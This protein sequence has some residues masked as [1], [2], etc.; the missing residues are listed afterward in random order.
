[1]NWSNA[2][3]A[4]SVSLWLLD[5]YLL[6]TLLLGLA[7]LGLRWVRQP[8]HRLTVA[9]IVTIELAALAGVCALPG[10]PKI[11]LV[12]VIPTQAALPPA[13]SVT[14]IPGEPPALPHGVTLERHGASDTPRRDQAAADRK[15]ATTASSEAPAFSDLHWGSAL[16]FLPALVTGG[17]LVG[18]G[19]VGLWLGWGA[20]ATVL[21]CRRATAAPPALAAELAKIVG[22]GPPPRLLLSRRI[23]NAAALGVL[24]PTILLPYG[25]AEAGPPRSLRAVLKHEWAH[26]RKHDLWVLALERCLL[27]VLFA[28]PLYWWLRRRIRDDQEAVADALAAQENRNDYAE[29]LLHWVRLT[30]N[31]SAVHAAAAAGIWESSSQLT[32]RIAML[33]DETFRVQ[34]A[35][36]RRWKYRASALLLLLGAAFSLVTLQ[37]DRSTAE[38]SP[39]P[40]PTKR[41]KPTEEPAGESRII[42]TVENRAA[43]RGN[44]RREQTKNGLPIR[45]AGHCLDGKGKPVD[46]AEVLLFRIDWE[47]VSQRQMLSMRSDGQG[48]FDF[49]LVPNIDKR[50]RGRIG[51]YRVIARSPGKATAWAEVPGPQTNAG[52]LELLLSEP[53]TFSGKVSD[54]HHKPV[55]G[56][57]I[58]KGAFYEP[59]AELAS[60]KTDAD[61][62]FEIRDLQPFEPASPKNLGNIT[63]AVASIMFRVRHPQYATKMLSVTRVPGSVEVTLE[64]PAVIEGRVVYGGTGSPAANVFVQTQGT[65]QHAFAQVLTDA[66]GRYR[67]DSLSS[68]N[69]NIWAKAEDWTVEAIDSFEAVAGQAKTAPDLRLVHGGLIVGR[70]IDKDTG[71]PVDPEND[72]RLTD[73]F[74]RPDVAFYGPSRPRSGAACETVPIQRDGSFRLRTALGKTWVYVRMGLVGE[75]SSECSVR[76]GNIY[77]AEDQTVEIE[78]RVRGDVRGPRPGDNQP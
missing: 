74:H 34:T 58:W 22:D 78:F 64:P 60:A 50:D 67:L 49:G 55:A 8:V 16:P 4:E 10:W 76:G 44:P 2:A 75:W 20:V 48:K 36:S 66:K 13:E 51:I 68:D 42:P 19:L 32:R 28:H 45:I 21:L 77:V 27:T 35:A 46:D 40:E 1:M 24:R 29:E 73:Q 43:S 62:S 23:G 63:Y 11:S 6:A 69:Y 70:V 71:L 31:L 15:S 57:E 37:P 25:L 14:G 59:V 54:A 26:I 61:G 7:F 5:F 47:V 72:P 12:A 9:W 65:T 30:V 41:S 39:P 56:A 38:Q 33:L 17:F 3:F 18:V 52:E 53:A